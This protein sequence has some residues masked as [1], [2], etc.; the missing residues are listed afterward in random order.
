VLGVIPYL[1][2]LN[3]PDEDSLALNRYR[4]RS[5]A[6]LD[7]LEI[8][9]VDTP[10]LANF[11]DVLPLASEPGVRL[12]LTAAA[13]ELLEADLVVLPGSKATVYDLSALRAL[14]I[15]RALAER[16]ARDLPIVGICGG[17]QILG[18]R[19]EDPTGIESDQPLVP[20][21][22][23][24]PHSTRYA[25]PK[26]TERR[27][28]VFSALGPSARVEGF[29]LH[30]G[31]MFDAQHPAL[32]LDDGTP[33]GSTRGSIVASMLHRMFD[34]ASARS[35]LLDWLRS[36]RGLPVPTDSVPPAPDP[37]ERL[38]D[39]VQRALDWPRLRS[40]ALRG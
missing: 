14:G 33:E 40:I 39:H 21:L 9:V 16:A 30:Y 8:A 25:N 32:Q 29:E 22:G 6:A 20:A 10:C 26:V 4:N 7:E 1:P 18:Q 11:E 23:L 19:I 2:N 36:L 3:L 34:Q 27:S 12:R 28:G 15:D 5:R 31:R 37:F 17:A 35:A 13:R 38:A 24:L